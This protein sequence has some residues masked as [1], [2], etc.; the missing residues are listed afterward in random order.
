[1]NSAAWHN[2]CGLEHRFFMAFSFVLHVRYKKTHIWL[3]GDWKRLT[4]DEA[5]LISLCGV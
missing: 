2:Y 3:I 1:M 4:Q 5:M